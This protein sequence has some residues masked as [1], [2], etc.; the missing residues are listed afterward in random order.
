[1]MTLIVKALIIVGS[2]IAGI[3]SVYVFK[4][5]HDNAV[6]E[7]AEEVIKKQTGVDVDLTPSSVEKE[8]PA[9]K[10]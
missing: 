5:P 9:D 10:S 2:L 1:M 4:M 8:T 7:V 6:E 3:G